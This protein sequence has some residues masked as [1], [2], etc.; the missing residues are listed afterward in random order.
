MKLEKTIILAISLMATSSAY[1]QYTSDAFRFSQFENSVDARFGAMGGAKTAIG[2][3]ISSIYGNPAGLGM[4]SKSEFSLTPELSLNSNKV[5]A[6]GTESS[7]DKNYLGLGNIGVVFHTRTYSS[8]DT[9]KGLLSLNFGI[10][11]QKKRSFTNDFNFNGT[12]NSNGLGDLF[13]QASNNDI[14]DDGYPAIPSRLLSDVHYAANVS[15]LTDYDSN[16][17]DTEPYSPITSTDSE[18]KYNIQ[19]RGTS[20][21]VDF[22]LGLNISNK[23]FLGAGLGLA[24]FNYTSTERINEDGVYSIPGSNVNT[25]YNVDYDKYYDTQ[26]S[27]INLK[28]GA[29]FKPT[30][31]V[32]LGLSFE[33][34]TWYSVIDNYSESFYDNRVSSRGEEGYPF[35]YSLKTPLKINGGLAYFIGSK[36]FISADIGFV[37][38][39]KIKFSSNNNRIDSDTKRDVTNIYQ[40][41]INYSIGGEYKVNNSFLLRAG[42]SSTGN[43]YQ[44]LSDKDYT[45]SSVSGGVG[46]RF[47]D[48]YLDAALINSN[49]DLNYSNYTL[50]AGNQPNAA[51]ETRTNK[52]SLTFGVRF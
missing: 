5:N 45:I 40:N 48:Y 46:Y 32:R 17:F 18:Q 7:L 25:I 30:N 13:S 35:E 22:S 44:N 34:P 21:S 47:G 28:M 19:R 39:S 24:N 11:Y 15:K 6:F 38:Y 50:N 42:Y 16:F 49:S 1:A 29:I 36:G 8:G 33:S 2:G 31:E 23:L 4:F 27:G 52:V 3:D 10:G 12:T 51:I 26:G 14:D 9:K 37:D 41:T 20:S 43:P